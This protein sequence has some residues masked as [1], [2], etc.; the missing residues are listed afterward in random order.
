MTVT[1]PDTFSEQ[2]LWAPKDSAPTLISPNWV[3]HIPSFPFPLSNPATASQH[4]FLLNNNNH[5]NNFMQGISSFLTL[6]RTIFWEEM[7]FVTTAGLRIIDPASAFYR[8]K[9]LS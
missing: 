4:F 9:I 1:S 2:K 6:L 8:K 5:N 3:V 7:S